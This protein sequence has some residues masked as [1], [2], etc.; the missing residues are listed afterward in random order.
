MPK[1]PALPTVTAARTRARSSKAA[2]G[3]SPGVLLAVYAPLG[4]DEALSR[5]PNEN[6]AAPI[7]PIEQQALVKALQA[8][9]AEGV[10]VCALVDVFDDDSYL[11][12][13]PA[14]RPA[15]MSVMSTWKQDMS[16][17]H[18][19][20]AFLRRAHQRFPCDALVLAI[21]GHGGGFVPDIDYGRITPASVT[22]VVGGTQRV[23]WVQTASLVTVEADPAALP[24]QMISP[25]LASAERGAPA[26]TRTPTPRDGMS[27]PL[28]M[29]S[30]TLQ[31]VSP[32]LPP[33][34]L[35]MSTWAYGEALR[36][37]I[38]AGVPKPVVI[39]FNNCFNAS[40]ELL[41]TVAPF[42][43]FASAYANYDFFTAGAAY[44][45]VFRNLR[46]AGTATAEQLARWFVKENGELL[47][48]KG[49]HPIIGATVRLSRMAGVTDKLAQ[50][51]RKLTAALRSSTGEA[52]RDTV[53][54][55]ARD[56]QHYDTVPGYVLKVPDQFID[57]GS[58]ARALALGFAA[59]DPDIAAAAEAVRVAASGLWQWGDDDWPW[60]GRD[61][62]IRYDFRDTQLGL[63]IFFPD[64][65]LDGI[66]D[67]RS[68]YYLSGTV[69]PAKP[70][71][72]RHVIPFLADVAGRSPAWVE[73]IVEYH[74]TTKFKGFHP[75]QPFVFPVFNRK[76]DPKADGNGPKPP[77]TG[78]PRG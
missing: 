12:E 55:A 78:K 26:E 30:P 49:N 64:P 35:P 6:P 70:P 36:L 25:T 45:C 3:R 58:F 50:L 40:T 68:P 37:A 63:N 61:P 73:F 29:V 21:E 2:T 75:P 47:R 51:S 31:M 53:A 65:G 7:A 9:A 14:F 44:P 27:P 74:N 34:R 17:R 8:T 42:A 43:G 41:H 24:R 15:A 4:T 5:Y 66:W 77:T 39:H 20:T 28:Q 56:A 48:H 32:T 18:A 67:W 22:Q 16:D 11:V 46:L 1:L 60:M 59:S 72:H 69:D 57:V 76:F 52:V 10:N 33:G 62:S 23:R 54:Q 13:I 71:A 38:K 19:L